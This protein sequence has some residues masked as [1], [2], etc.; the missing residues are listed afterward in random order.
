MIKKNG[1]ISMTL[2]YSFLILFLGIMGAILAT[3]S[4]KN[5]Y[6]TFINEQV[7][8]DL[9]EIKGK[10]STIINRILEDNVAVNASE[11]DSNGN[12][13][14]RLD[15]IAN[16]T[17]GNGNGF[18]YIDDDNKTDE[19]GDGIGSR[20]YFFRGTAKTNYV[21]MY[22]TAKEESAMCFRII[23]TNE[24]SNVRMIYAG[25][26]IQE[27]G[28]FRCD[29]GN[30]T[31]IGK[32]A[33]N[34]ISNDNAYVGFSYGKPETIFGSRTGEASQLFYNRDNVCEVHSRFSD[35]HKYFDSDL[36]TTDGNFVCFSEKDG[37]TID[38]NFK[39]T[40]RLK[41]EDWYVTNLSQMSDIITDSIFCNNRY[42][43]DTLNKGFG[44]VATTYEG[45]KNYSF[46]CEFD[47][48]MFRLSI[49]SGGNSEEV[50]ALTYP[51]GLPTASD[52]TFAGGSFGSNNEQTYMYMGHD[53]WTMSA[54][55]FDTNAKEYS[56]TDGT[57]KA[58]TVTNKLDIYPVISI[59][60]N[61]SVISGSGTKNKPYVISV[62]PMS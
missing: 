20:I 19:N 24:D 7:D 13:K 3:Y 17:I 37:T 2:V 34:S 16:S 33:F 46:R 61:T 23:R 26:A 42:V 11:L 55:K 9:T 40:V 54:A 18:F 59:K 62:T 21:V 29:D 32:S 45:A 49:N 36:T 25:K 44:T 14:I 22:N 5:N 41:L 4:E 52:I 28:N 47:Q 38:R 12:K 8:T 30:I 60:S 57:L 51:I 27:G 6:N 43:E 39:S 31:S 56:Y 50:D 10:S 35:T 58:T 53:Y 1:F 15:K 48:D